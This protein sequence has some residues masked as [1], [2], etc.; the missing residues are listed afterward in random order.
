MTKQIGVVTGTSEAI[1]G[2]YTVLEVIVTTGDTFDVPG[3]ATIARVLAMKMTDW[4]V[5]TCTSSGNTVTVTQAGLS[6]DKIVA[7]VAG[8]K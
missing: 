1:I 8:Q 6:T 4:S 7:L 2:Y 5:V 3:L